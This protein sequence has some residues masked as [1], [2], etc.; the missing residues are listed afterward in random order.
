MFENSDNTE[1]NPKHQQNE[2]T[3]STRDAAG[4]KQQPVLVEHGLDFLNRRDFILVFLRL[5]TQEI[6]ASSVISVAL[7]GGNQS[8][9]SSSSRAH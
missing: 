4:A 1:K 3:S 5:E 6:S 8:F 9:L 7:N 2:K